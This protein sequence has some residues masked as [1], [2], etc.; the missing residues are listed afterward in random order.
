VIDTER[1]FG[2]VSDVVKKIA[3]V[4]QVDVFDLYQ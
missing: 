4:Q 3:G 1:G 2:E